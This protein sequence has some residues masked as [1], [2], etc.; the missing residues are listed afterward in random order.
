MNR[1]SVAEVNIAKLQLENS[2]KA[3]HRC[4][5]NFFYKFLIIITVQCAS[6]LGTFL[7]QHNKDLKRRKC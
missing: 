3:C 4:K 1:N 5:K 7:K 6:F 2:K